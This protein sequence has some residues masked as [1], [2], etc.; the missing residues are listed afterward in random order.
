[1][2]EFEVEDILDLEDE[3]VSRTILLEILSKYGVCHVSIDGREALTAFKNS[4][5]KGKTYDLICMDIVMPNMDGLEA[6]RRIR[7]LEQEK[8][9]KP[10]DEVKIIM[11]TVKRDP[12]TVIKSLYKSGANAYIPKLIDEKNL[13]REIA[14]PG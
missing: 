7:R 6:V 2:L 9:V 8:A 5:E 14:K 13:H 4:L 1:M 3:F 10:A 11:T 12:K